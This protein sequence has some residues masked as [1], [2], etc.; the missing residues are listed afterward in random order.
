M[1]KVKLLF[2]VQKWCQENKNSFY[3]E[4]QEECESYFVEHINL[5][6]IDSEKTLCM[7]Q[8][9]HAYPEENY[10]VIM[11]YQKLRTDLSFMSP[12]KIR[13][14]AKAFEKMIFIC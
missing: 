14:N 12:N 6:D 11:A 4:L 8:F 3:D 1:S 7:L 10:E 13:V 5:K 9:S 2:Q